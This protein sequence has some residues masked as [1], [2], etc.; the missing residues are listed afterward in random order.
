MA[1]NG[2]QQVANGLRNMDAK[3]IKSKIEKIQ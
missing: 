3:A 1:L 2:A